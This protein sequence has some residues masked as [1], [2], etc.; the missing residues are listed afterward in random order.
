MKFSPTSALQRKNSGF[1]FRW[2]FEEAIKDWF[3]DNNNQ[4]LE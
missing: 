2:T 3:A 1:Q 4:Y